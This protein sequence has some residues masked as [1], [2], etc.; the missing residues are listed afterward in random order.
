MSRPSYS[1]RHWQYSHR[2]RHERNRFQF[3]R[4]GLEHLEFRCLLTAVPYT[5]NDAQ[6]GAGGFLDGI[7]FDPSHNGT[8]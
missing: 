3:R 2:R 7:F 8:M 4:T 5:W 6:I 1:R